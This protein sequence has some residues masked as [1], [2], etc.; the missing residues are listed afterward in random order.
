[1]IWGGCSINGLGLVNECESSECPHYTAICL[2]VCVHSCLKRHAPWAIMCCPLLFL[3]PGSQHMDTNWALASTICA[4]A[5]VWPPSPLRWLPGQS[6]MGCLFQLL[7]IYTQHSGEG[8][9]PFPV[10]QK[11]FQRT[12]F[13]FGKCKQAQF[14]PVLEM[15]FFLS[16]ALYQLQYTY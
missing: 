10:K 13:S 7:L 11:G 8:V 4:P 3:E 15:A 16:R 2:R 6:C 9:R 12:F 5:A 14:S 1:M